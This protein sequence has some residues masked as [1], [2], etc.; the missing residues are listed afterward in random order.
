MSKQH[1]QAFFVSLVMAITAIASA[2]SGYSISEFGLNFIADHEGIRYNLYNDPVGHCT[3]GI[4]HLVHK[5][6]CDGSDASEQEFLEGITEDRAHELLRSDIAVAERAVN[7]YVTVPLTQ[8][9]F[10]A[11]V[12]FAYNIG[13]GNFRNSDLLAK[14]NTGDYDS[15]PK[16][17]NKWIYG[18]GKVLPGLKT[19]RSDE[20]SLFQSE[21]MDSDASRMITL[22]LYIHDRGEDGPAIPNAIVSGQDGS[23]NNFRETAGESG[24]AAIAGD[25]GTWSFEASADGY[26]TNSWSQ[27]ITDTCTK[28]AFLKQSSGSAFM[29]NSESS[30]VGKWA[31]HFIR[32]SWESSSEKVTRGPDSKDEWDSIVEFHSDGTFTESTSYMT[33]AGE[34]TQDANNIRLQDSLEFRDGSG[35]YVSASQ[36]SE[37]RDGII[38][39]STMNGR[40][41]IRTQMTITGD[42]SYSA[43]IS[44]A[45]TWSAN[46]IE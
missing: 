2:Q 14:L 15:V 10:D 33:F 27:K 17:L 31:F 38:E 7:D 37:S 36:T 8:S 39:G 41:S 12:S 3:I 44:E 20:G 29:H 45:Y 1:H 6:N 4:G 28:H 5:G 24:L 22:T 25:S 35:N 13:S 32:E 26:E 34:W 43:D 40:G 9:Q 21:V 46:R 19:R 30:V 11:L 18:G 42:D 23:G 16:E